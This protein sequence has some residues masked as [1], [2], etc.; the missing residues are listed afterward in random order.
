MDDPE[1]AQLA[2]KSDLRQLEGGQTDENGPEPVAEPVLIG[3][4]SILPQ[5]DGGETDEEEDEEEPADDSN[6]E[7]FVPSH[8]ATTSRRSDRTDRR[9][10]QSL[11]R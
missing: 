6:D 5:L 1:P 7:D 9:A 8:R 10:K 4:R 11:S 2:D 3:Q